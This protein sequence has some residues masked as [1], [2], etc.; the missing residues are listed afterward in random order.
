MVVFAP[1]LPIKRGWTP[2][3]Q[4]KLGH[5]LLASLTAWR[6]QQLSTLPPPSDR[7][8]FASVLECRP[9]LGIA[10]VLHSNGKPLSPDIRFLGSVWDRRPLFGNRPGDDLIREWPTLDHVPQLPVL[11]SATVDSALGRHRSPCWSCSLSSS[12]ICIDYNLQ[13]SCPFADLQHH[14]WHQFSFSLS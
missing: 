5:R 10:L 9:F 12:S 8:H 2:L 7:H 11:H 13:K 3:W 6:R 1:R 14:T 4:R